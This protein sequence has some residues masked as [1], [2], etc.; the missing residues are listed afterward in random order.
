MC[1]YYINKHKI[2]A[3]VRKIVQNQDLLSIFQINFN[4]KIFGNDLI[5]FF[6]FGKIT[7]EYYDLKNEDVEN[8]KDNLEIKTIEKVR[9]HSVS[10]L[11]YHGKF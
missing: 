7:K 9:K 5:N 6:R 11:K 1:K 3:Q 2:C 10:P 4:F 8:V